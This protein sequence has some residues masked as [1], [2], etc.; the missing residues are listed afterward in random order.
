MK[1][2]RRT[3]LGILFLAATA[4]LVGP[5]INAFAQGDTPSAGKGERAA[6]TPAPVYEISNEGD[7]RGSPRFPA[8]Q[9]RAAEDCDRAAEAY[10]QTKVPSGMSSPLVLKDFSSA[11]IVRQ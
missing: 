2:Q 10:R 1:T 6:T 11:M 7:N 3:R 5:A 4:L 9:H 8:L